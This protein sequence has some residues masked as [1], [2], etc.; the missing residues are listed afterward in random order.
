MF[1]LMFSLGPI[2]E[3]PSIVRPEL[4]F[5]YLISE[6]LRNW[7]EAQSWC[8]ERGYYLLY[9][10]SDQEQHFVKT[11]LASIIP[12]MPVH[13]NTTYRVGMLAFV[14]LL[15]PFTCNSNGFTFRFCK[16]FTMAV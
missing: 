14:F 15:Q 16:E 5:S 7:T 8:L 1:F 9:I 4:G 13:P 11:W 10:D 12:S 6:V 3:Y 2:P